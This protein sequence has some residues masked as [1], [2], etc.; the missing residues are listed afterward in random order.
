MQVLLSYRVFDEEGEALHDVPDELSL[1]VG[2]GALLP[3]IEERLEG[4][5]QGEQRTVELSPDDAFG[6]RDPKAVIEVDRDEFPPDVAPGDRFDAESDDGRPVLLQVL[7]VSDQAVVLDGNHPLA[8]QR[9]RFEI[10]VREVRP[11][12]AEELAAAEKRLEVADDPGDSPL[13]S[14]VP[15]ERL[16]RGPSRR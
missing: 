14:L 10:T 5:R 2:Y 13:G 7:D 16:L 11:A 4:L 3:A 8:G 6:R 9:V 1:V 15:V 12:S